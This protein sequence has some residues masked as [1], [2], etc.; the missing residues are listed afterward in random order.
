MISPIVSGR[1]VKIALGAVALDTLLFTGVPYAGW[2]A[3]GPPSV[4]V[5]VLNLAMVPV[6]FLRRRAPVLICL[7]LCGYAAA[8][9]LT[10]GSRPL[11]SLLVALFTAAALRPARYSGWCLAAILGTHAVNLSYQASLATREGNPWTTVLVV[12]IALV[13]F[14]L[15][16]WFLGRWAAESRR[17]ARELVRTSEARAAKAV[18]DERLRIAR[19][20]HDIVAH[21]V[22]VM[23]LQTSGARRVLVKDPASAETALASVEEVGKQ[24]MAELRRLLQ[25]LRTVGSTDEE[26][27]EAGMI[28]GLKDLDPLVEQTRAAGVTVDLST[29][30][31]EGR[32]HSSV[33]LSVYR[34]VQEALTNVVRHAGPGTHV[35]VRVARADDTV[36]VEVAD[37][38]SG[39]VNSV[40]QELTSGYGLAGLHERIKLMGGEIST[41]PLDDGGY[42]VRAT[43]PAVSP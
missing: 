35:R 29:S 10:V 17:R 31:L 6:L 11:A 5:V 20:L 37:D 13:V 23:V 24:A 9:T 12:G 8:L 30:G 14:D 27:L 16:A 3:L 34:V 41:G 19:E 18:A 4:T 40:A 22:T 15:A 26:A 33:E 7:I 38:G 36:T 28:A 42:S 39:T 2:S 21:A 32:L 43:L 1:D 25:V